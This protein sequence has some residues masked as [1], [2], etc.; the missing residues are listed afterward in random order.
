[1]L[2]DETIN[3]VARH[4]FI[5]KTV[6]GFIFGSLAFIAGIVATIVCCVTG[7]TEL[8]TLFI[9]L[10]LVGLFVAAICGIFLFGKNKK[11]EE[12]KEKL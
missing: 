6:V 11:K 5:I 8:I 3:K 1:M 4:D 10:A 7:S 12:I 9:A 2:D